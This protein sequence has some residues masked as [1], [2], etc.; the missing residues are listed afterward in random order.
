[1][2]NLFYVF[3]ILNRCLFPP[4]LFPIVV[5]NCSWTRTEISIRRTGLLQSNWKHR[6]NVIHT[7]SKSKMIDRILPN[8]SHEKVHSNRD[9][10][11]NKAVQRQK[12]KSTVI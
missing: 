3:L 12:G 10:T 4:L 2:R 7:K 6:L 8:F 1:M 5:I 9:I 11:I